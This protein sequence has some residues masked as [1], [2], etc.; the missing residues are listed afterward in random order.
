MKQLG[1]LLRVL[2]ILGINVLDENNSRLNRAFKA[3]QT[4][5]FPILIT[6]FMCY[7][8]CS[9]II[10]EPLN[11]TTFILIS[12]TVLPN[13]M[14]CT[15]YLKR[16]S[17][18]KLLDH[19][20]TEKSYTR[21]VPPL[22]S[23]AVNAFVIFGFVFPPI[24]Q[25][26]VFYFNGHF[27]SLSNLDIVSDYCL[28]IHEILFPTILATTYSSLCSILFRRLKFSHAQLR[29]VPATSDP[30]K[31][32]SLV[33]DYLDVVFV[34]GIFQETFSA[35]VFFLMWQNICTVSFSLMEALFDQ[36]RF[37]E[38][39]LVDAVLYIVHACGV[40]GVVT[41]VAAEIPLEMQRIKSSLIAINF[42]RL[43]K[44]ELVFGEKYID[45]ILRMDLTVLTALNVFSFDRGF[46]L[47]ALAALMAQV[48]VFY[49][50]INY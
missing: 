5:I 24:M 21:K 4:Y 32:K 13:I 37:V 31:V 10:E 15:T 2:S 35:P 3:A 1:V 7:K 6:S 12:V 44:N 39:K 17:F 20:N 23:F 29:Q 41:V 46:L 42:Q 50:I 45:M 28:K 30:N 49:Q 33:Q 19:L 34:I 27:Y 18:K 40:I 36:T 38:S 43:L 47:K 22:K 26:M 16:S 48:L 14:W 11:S 8:T 25:T 9:T